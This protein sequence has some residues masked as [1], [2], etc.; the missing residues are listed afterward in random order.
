MGNDDIAQAPPLQLAGYQG[1]ALRTFP[2]RR[3]RAV[4]EREPPLMLGMVFVVERE[5]G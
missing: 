3:L 2:A 5:H 4:D 1:R